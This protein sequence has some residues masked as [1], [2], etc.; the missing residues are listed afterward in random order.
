M[1]DFEKLDVFAVV[2]NLNIE[3]YNHLKNNKIDDYIRDQ[4]QRASFSIVL[5]LAEGVGRISV[6]DKKRFLTIARGSV[7]EC[8]AIMRF[9]HKTGMLDEENFGLFYNEYEKASKMLLG[10]FRS[11]N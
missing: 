7:F 10:M 4:W 2:E 1:F 3:V 5:N 6:N 9:L 8:V 11:Y